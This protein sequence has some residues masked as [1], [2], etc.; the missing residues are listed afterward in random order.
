MYFWLMILMFSV[1]LPSLIVCCRFRKE[2]RELRDEQQRIYCSL[3]KIAE[4]YEDAYP[5]VTITARFVMFSELVDDD[6]ELQ[7]LDELLRNEL[8]LEA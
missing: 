5:P 2:N 8:P 1:L 4:R 3:S 6:E 7:L